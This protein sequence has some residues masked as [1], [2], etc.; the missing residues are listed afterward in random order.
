MRRRNSSL[1][2]SP[3]R[4]RSSSVLPKCCRH[5]PTPRFLL[6]SSAPESRWPFPITAV[7]IAFSHT[8]C[9]FGQFSHLGSQVARIRLLIQLQNPAFRLAF[10]RVGATAPVLKT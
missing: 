10:S 2:T 6:S 5:R 4:T 7:F 1:P 3:Y 8:K 9:V